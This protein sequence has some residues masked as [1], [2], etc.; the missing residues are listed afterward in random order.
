MAIHFKIA[1]FLPAPLTQ[2]KRQFSTLFW[3][4]S[5]VPSRLC[6]DVVRFG[7]AA[8]I[9]EA[10][11]AT[12]QPQREIAKTCRHFFF[13]SNQLIKCLDGAGEHF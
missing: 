3:I 4:I 13:K 9:V 8:I 11:H 12:F 1:T 6:A 5:K 7:V 10:A 2:Y